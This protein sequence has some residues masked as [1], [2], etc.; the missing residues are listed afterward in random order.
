MQIEW[1]T[2]L[3]LLNHYDFLRDKQQ[4]TCTNRGEF[5]GMYGCIS[6]FPKQ[7][8]SK[9]FHTDFPSTHHHQRLL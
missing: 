3:K 9:Q 7:P 4:E 1:N 2:I 6:Y 5:V 8:L